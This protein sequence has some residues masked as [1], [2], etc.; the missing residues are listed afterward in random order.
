M[1]LHLW[2]VHVWSGHCGKSARYT[3]G[4]NH[5]PLNY[6]RLREQLLIP[7][8]LAALFQASAARARAG[9]EGNAWHLT[10]DVVTAG[11]HEQRLCLNLATA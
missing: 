7:S 5:Q 8:A 3:K 10:Q 11:H 9:S 4:L 2:A 6:Q 1:I